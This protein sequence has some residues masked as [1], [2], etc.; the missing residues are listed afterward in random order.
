[1]RIFLVALGVLGVLGCV[2]LPS[3]SP[4]T[5]KPDPDEALTLAGE[6]LARGDDQAAAA[7]FETYVRAHPEQIMFRLDLANL[8][9][10]LH[11]LAEAR[12]HYERF[13]ADA[14]ASTGPPRD[15]LVHCR[16]RLMEIAQMNGDEFSELLHRGIGLV[17]LGRSSA[18][19]DPLRE[20]M[21]CRA[22]QAL[23][24]AARLRPNDPRVQV[25]LAE[26]HERAGNPEAAAICRAAARMRAAPGSLTPTEALQLGRE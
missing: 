13:I 4:G 20:V 10:K 5:E 1:M 14:Q 19:D 8:D 23:R 15:Q 12:G 9:F 25:Y 22:I 24:D 3:P 2:S 11:R 16:T 21:L 26:A 18:A 7:H 17:V 6:A